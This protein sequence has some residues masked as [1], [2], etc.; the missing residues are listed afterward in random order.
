MKVWK[1]KTAGNEIDNL[2]ALLYKTAT[3]LIIDDSR[4]KKEMSLEQLQD[5]GMEPQYEQ[6]SHIESNIEVKRVL[7]IMEQVDEKYRDVVIMRYIDD[8]KP[9][10]IAEIVGESANN[11]SVRINRG[12]KKV[13][14]LL[15]IAP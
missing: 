7:K 12:I 13:R 3:N 2:R 5:E 15:E 11:V 6:S 4:K 14:E 1:Y 8:L 10:E 9:E